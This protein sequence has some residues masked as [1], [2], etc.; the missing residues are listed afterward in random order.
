MVVVE[1]AFTDHPTRLELR[2][3]HRQILAELHAAGE[4]AVAG[5]FDDGSGS[6]VVFTSSRERVEEVLRMDPYYT[7]D[8]VTIVA[9]RELTPLFTD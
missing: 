6:L 4:V 9:V 5:P 1:L 3:R 2:P 8:G 7:A